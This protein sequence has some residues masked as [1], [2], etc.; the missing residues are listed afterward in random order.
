MS[1]KSTTDTLIIMQINK[2]NLYCDVDGVIN[3]AARKMILGMKSQIIYRKLPSIG[4]NFA[5]V[6]LR[7]RWQDEIAL[8]LAALSVNF[9][10]LTTW[11]HQAV[12]ILE[13]LTG[14][15]SVGVLPYNINLREIH[16]QKT[17]YDILKQHQENSIT[18]FI[19]IDD[20]ATQHYQKHHFPEDQPHLIIRTNK[21]FGITN[22]HMLQINEFILNPI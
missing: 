10:W 20:V 16:N 2:P 13:P 8:N 17:K 11:N 9:Y 4:Q 22:D 7:I 3:I 14:I 21:R 12:S 18:P 1:P 5:P 6:P 19:W 15:K